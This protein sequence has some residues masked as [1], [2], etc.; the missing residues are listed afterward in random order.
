[1]KILFLLIGALLFVSQSALALDV[2]QRFEHLDTNNNGYL[3]QCEL[4]AQPQ[5]LNT[6]SKW[7][8][9]Q[10]NRISMAEFKNYLTHNL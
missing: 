2:K 1:M 8:K 3:T 6:F 9:N 10:D 5:L 7:D 4:D